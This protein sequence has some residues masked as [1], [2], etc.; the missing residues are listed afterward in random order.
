MHC[1]PTHW[2][3]VIVHHVGSR[4]S[5]NCIWF[6]GSSQPGSAAAGNATWYPLKQVL[7]YACRHHDK[8]LHAQ[9]DKASNAVT[10]SRK[11]A[12]PQQ[13]QRHDPEGE[14]R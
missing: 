7:T 12:V 5:L 9:Q 13:R 14:Q 1:Y 11:T 2:L 4:F 6:E 10:R 3:V 8:Q